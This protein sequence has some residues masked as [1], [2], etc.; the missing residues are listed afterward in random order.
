MTQG[1][2]VQA[3]VLKVDIEKKRIS[4]SLRRSSDAAPAHTKPRREPRAAR[5]APK[6]PK[7]GTAAGGSVSLTH[8]MADQLG[9]LKDKL[10]EQ[11]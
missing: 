3:R 7:T 6:E 5:S 11:E 8:T 9:R 10:R 4:L 1:Q 2:E